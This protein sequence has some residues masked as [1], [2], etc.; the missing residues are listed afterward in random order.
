MR[1]ALFNGH[2]REA[3][4]GLSGHCRVCGDLT[5]AKCGQ[6]RIWHWAHKGVRTCD[7]WWELETQWHRDWK[8]HFPK[9][10]QEAIHS[11]PDGEKHIADVKTESDVVIE[12]QH[13]F[14]PIA[15]RQSREAFYPKLVWVVDGRRRAR[16]RLQFFSALG[17]V[18]LQQPMIISA[19][20]SDSALLR[21]WKTSRVPVYFDFG[22]SDPV[23]PVRFDEPTL[24]RLNPVSESQGA[25]LSPVAKS[26][27]VGI[28]RTGVVF[29]EPFTEE[30]TRFAERHRRLQ[31]RSFRPHTAF[32]HCVADRQRT[33]GRF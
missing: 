4:P 31:S 23:D 24:W 13:S 2:S 33:R 17:S 19:R 25:Y 26:Y 1:F 20:I 32:D 6:H 7:Q 28:H 9:E 14:L 18:L 27:F 29:D 12:F 11:A 3:E 5:I 8:D 10:W 16:D 30:L 22:P 15:E 21:D